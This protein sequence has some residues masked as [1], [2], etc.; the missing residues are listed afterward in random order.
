MSGYLESN[1][2]IAR[3][4]A[5]PRCKELFSIVT[6]CVHQRHEQRGHQAVLEARKLLPFPA[7]DRNMVSVSMG[8]GMTVRFIP[9]LGTAR[10]VLNNTH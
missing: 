3:S 8:M 2:G 4:E 10:V 6:F 9:A 5:R 7:L 1:G